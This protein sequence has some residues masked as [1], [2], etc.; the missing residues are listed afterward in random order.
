MC[1]PVY[2]LLLPLLCCVL[3]PHARVLSQ[4][5]RAGLHDY[6]DTWY[7]YVTLEDG[8]VDVTPFD[9][10]HRLNKT[11]VC[12]VRWHAHKLCLGEV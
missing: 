5:M 7:R 1:A 2:L 12:Q 10:L 4:G 3:L 8:N 6:N 11:F 9:L